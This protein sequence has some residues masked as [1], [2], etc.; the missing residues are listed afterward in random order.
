MKMQPYLLLSLLLLLSSCRRSAP[1]PDDLDK[2]VAAWFITPHLVELDS[3]TRFQLT[4]PQW[5]SIIGRST[6][7]SAEAGAFKKELRDTRKRRYTMG[8]ITPDTIRIDT[9]YPLILYLHGGIGTQVT[10]KG[11]LAWDMLTPLTDTFNL[12]LAS[13]SANRQAPWWSPQGIERILQTLRFMSVRYPIN[14]DKV[15][16][17]GVSDGGTGCFAAASTIPAHF[18][19]FFAV[20]CHPGMLAQAGFRMVIDNVKQRPI[21]LVHAGNDGLY[22]WQYVKPFLDSLKTSGVPLSI[23]FYPDE[24]HGF[25]YRAQ[26][27]GTIARLIREWSRP[28]DDRNFDWTYVPHY[29]NHADNCFNWSVTDIGKELPRV[30]GRWN[31]EQLAIAG[32]NVASLT[33]VTRSQLPS[34][35]YAQHNGQMQAA[36]KIPFD[37][38]RV[39]KFSQYR[40]F[41]TPSKQ[42]SLYDL[43][44]SEK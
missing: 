33:L 1:L 19:G 2:K 14:P 5:D 24:Q 10:T 9:T 30:T 40:C 17:A 22:P 16:L 26:E 43:I 44:L 28:G 21:H 13:P 34:I 31:A 18:A 36:Q 29:P 42:V 41:L 39:L 38:A 27:F 37:I 12:F 15:F 6:E 8:W 7:I 35:K 4:H 20:S 23:S 32:E 3:L 11:E 25:D